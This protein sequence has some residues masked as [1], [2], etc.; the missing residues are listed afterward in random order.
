MPYDPDK[1]HRR[2][3]R[4]KGYDYALE[5]GYFITLVVQG[6]QCVL[7]KIDG[8]SEVSL[9]QPG[10]MIEYWLGR[11]VTRFDTLV[12]DTY[13]IMP[14]HFHG[15]FMLVDDDRPRQ[16]TGQRQ[17]GQ[18]HKETCFPS[19]PTADVL[20]SPTHASPVR[21]TLSTILQWFKSMTTNAYFKGVHDQD[22]PPVNK[23]LW[24]RN[25][26]ERIIHSDREWELIRDY[27]QRNPARWPS[28]PEH[29][30]G[31]V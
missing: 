3:I 9:S 8:D 16:S 15:I 6:R 31:A 4:L 17:P 30:A 23:R 20:D 14:N 28:D 7:G 27:I 26:Y 24:Q 22:W 2:S 11:L 1:H 25:Y 13:V 21:P 10:G 5:G 12:I 18:T 29:P 19:A